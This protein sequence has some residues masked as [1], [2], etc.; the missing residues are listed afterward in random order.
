MKKIEASGKVPINLA[1]MNLIVKNTDPRI[2]TDPDPLSKNKNTRNDETVESDGGASY[3][4]YLAVAALI[5][6]IY[7]GVRWYTSQESEVSS[8]DTAGENAHGGGQL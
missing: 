5:P 1:Q 8:G 4:K 7:F 3:G 6:I 2:E